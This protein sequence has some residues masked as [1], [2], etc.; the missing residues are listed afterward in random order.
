MII[1]S[2]FS[3]LFIHSEEKI[4]ELFMTAETENNPNMQQ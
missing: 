4:S 3:I 2:I 1:E